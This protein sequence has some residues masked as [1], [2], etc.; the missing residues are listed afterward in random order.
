MAMP[1]APEQAAPGPAIVRTTCDDADDD[2][3]ER[4]RG[5]R[6][7]ESGDPGSAAGA[8]R[9]GREDERR[10]RRAENGVRRREAQ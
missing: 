3:R 5:R 7:D 6:N 8:G 4:E 1:N 9:P 2:D 10:L